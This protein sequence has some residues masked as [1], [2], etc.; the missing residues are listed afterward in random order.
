MKGKKKEKKERVAL[1]LLVKLPFT[2]F[3]KYFGVWRREKAKAITMSIKQKNGDIITKNVK[4]DIYED[5]TWR[6]KP[7]KVKNMNEC[8]FLGELP[9]DE[10]LLFGH[11]RYFAVIDQNETT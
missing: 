10:I 11:K 4:A 5:P 2:G 7:S 1:P 8:K 6:F 9:K 3:L